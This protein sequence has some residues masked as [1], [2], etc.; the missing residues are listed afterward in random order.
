AVHTS[1]CVQD[2][3]APAGPCLNRRVRAY[4]RRDGRQSVLLKELARRAKSVCVDSRRPRTPV[5][6]QLLSEIESEPWVAK[7]HGQTRRRTLEK[8]SCSHAQRISSATDPLLSGK[9][10]RDDGW[11]S[12]QQ[13]RLA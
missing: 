13:L 9:C 2:A 11:S 10:C 4:D 3:E 1:L 12:G 7:Y 6:A 5:F 8:L